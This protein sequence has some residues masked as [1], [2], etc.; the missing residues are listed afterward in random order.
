MD[1]RKFLAGVAASGMLLVGGRSVVLA[2][3]HDGHDGGHDGGNG[4]PKCQPS[5]GP[6]GMGMQSSHAAQQWG[7]IAAATDH[8]NERHDP[9]L[10]VGQ[11]QQMIMEACRVLPNGR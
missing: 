6:N 1:R 7:G 3:E 9:D 5:N 8:H 2:E 10:T 4:G 11:H